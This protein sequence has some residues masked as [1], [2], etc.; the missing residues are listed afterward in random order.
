MADIEYKAY[1]KL[2]YYKAHQA[3]RLLRGYGDNA[4]QLEDIVQEC[5]LAFCLARDAFKAD[6]NVPFG[7][8]LARGINQHIRRWANYRLRDKTLFS[9]LEDN[10]GDDSEYTLHDL[11][12]DES[13]VMPDDAL[14]E[15]DMI[16][17]THDAMRW[18]KPENMVSERTRQFLDL[19]S[20]PPPQ[21]VDMFKGLQARA[22]YARQRG[23]TGVVSPAR[24][25]AAMIFN[26]M[27]AGRVERAAI[28]KEVHIL[29]AEISQQ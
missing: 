28:Y 19:L 17:F 10:V 23:M 9:H 22:E 29:A 11:T 13:A 8:F 20:N 27:G 24:I 3:L 12:P 26:L 2:L 7:A 18:R 14:I 16:E 15:K 5:A 4:T 25:T 6:Y 21:V 1:E